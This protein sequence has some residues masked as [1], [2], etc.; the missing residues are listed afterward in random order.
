M[1]FSAPHPT[2]PARWGRHVERTPFIAEATERCDYNIS[3]NESNEQLIIQNH[4]VIKPIALDFTAVFAD[5]PTGF[6]ILTNNKCRVTQPIHQV[7]S[8]TN[9]QYAKMSICI[10]NPTGKSRDW[11]NYMNYHCNITIW[12][13]NPDKWLSDLHNFGLP[14]ILSHT[15]A[16]PLQLNESASRLP[17]GNLDQVD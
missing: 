4:K 11:V 10:C 9:L 2:E 15:F 16:R 12:T 14:G 3:Y 7:L 5:G 13:R 6:K 1:P 8:E 17:N